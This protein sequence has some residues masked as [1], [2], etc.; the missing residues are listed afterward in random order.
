MHLPVRCLVASLVCFP[1]WAAAAE[2]HPVAEP[3]A[4]EAPAAVDKK[5][6]LALSN[7]QALQRLMEGNAR[8]LAGKAVHP[9]QDASRR[10]EVANSQKPFAIVL[11]CA[12]SRVSPEVIFD[13]G[14]GDIFVLRVAGNVA[15]ETVQ[16][17]IE[18]AVEHL[19]TN[20]I[21]V[22]GHER[23]GAVKAALAGGE[24]PGHLPALIERIKPA[25]ESSRAQAGDALNNAVSANARLAANQLRASRPLLQPRV[26][27]GSLAVIPAHLDLDTGAI[28]LLW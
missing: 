23:C 5:K 9:R 1:L 13:Q 10:S 8:Y 15:D 7:A 27:Q 16:A 28:E 21:V 24:L 20:L 4:T 2:D 18:Y 11:A 14:L 22:L 26:A 25:V 12:D 3:T 19:G 6:A 17:S